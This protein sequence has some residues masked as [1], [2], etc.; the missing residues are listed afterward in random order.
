[1]LI[2]GCKQSHT[3]GTLMIMSWFEAN[4]SKES[5]SSP[6]IKMQRASRARSCS[7]TDFCLR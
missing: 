4:L 5:S 2:R 7:M 6:T 3:S 1:M